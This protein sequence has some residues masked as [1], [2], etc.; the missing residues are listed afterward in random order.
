M[1]DEGFRGTAAQA[2]EGRYGEAAYAQGEIAAADIIAQQ[3]KAKAER[4][5]GYAAWRAG[6][7]F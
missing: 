5:Y 6:E 3:Q 7:D 1:A 4:D 2:E